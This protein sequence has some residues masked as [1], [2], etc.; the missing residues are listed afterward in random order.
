MTGDLR[1]F[2]AHI[3]D[4]SLLAGLSI[5]GTNIS[6]SSFVADSVN[7]FG[8]GTYITT[9]SS[10]CGF[11]GCDFGVE[12]GTHGIKNDDIQSV[13]FVLAHSTLDLTADL[14]ADQIFALR[15]SNVGTPDGDRSSFSKLSGK[16][17]VPEPSTAIM[18]LLGLTGLT[19]AGRTPKGQS[20]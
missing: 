13:T 11:E 10:G 3:A 1:G 18:M 20:A 16:V 2:Y 4:E 6:D 17:V 19:L 7:N 5:S 15:V 14:F 12:I 8:W 9:G